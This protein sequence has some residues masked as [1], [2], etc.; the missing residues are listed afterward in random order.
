MFR[1]N[2]ACV[3]MS[4]T[5]LCVLSYRVMGS[6]PGEYYVL[7]LTSFQMIHQICNAIYYIIREGAKVIVIMIMQ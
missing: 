6:P 3:Y 1:C 4:P 5:G 7:A 2:T